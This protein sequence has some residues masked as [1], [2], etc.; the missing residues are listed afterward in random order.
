VPY[1]QFLPAALVGSN[2]LPLLVLGYLAGPQLLRLIQNVGF[3]AQFLTVVASLGLLIAGGI[4]LRRR[5]HLHAAPADLAPALRLEVAL[6]AGAVATA[7]TV[8]VLNIGLYSVSM[9]QLG[10]PG[11]ALIALG[12]TLIIRLGI[13]S[14]AGLVIGGS[15]G[16]VLLYLG[17]AVGYGVLEPRL[18]K[19]DWLGGLLFSLLPLAASQLVLLPAIGAGVAGTG[20]EFGVGLLI[21]DTLRR[22][23]YGWALA[24]AYTLLTRARARPGGATGRA[25]PSA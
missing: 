20:L 6:W 4:L 16:Y 15:L 25:R 13:P 12:R 5:A 3:S 24:T 1:R 9:L 7:A 11:D 19:P 17:W 21:G 23:V 18:P 14:L 10:S 22:L 8:A 2:N